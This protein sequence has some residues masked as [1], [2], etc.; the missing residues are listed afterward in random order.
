MASERVLTLRD[1]DF[2]MVISESTAPVLVDFWAE[3]C[4]PCKMIAPVVEEVA[5][6][7]E[8]KI[9]VGKLNVDENQRTPA[10]LKVI[11]IP[12]LIVFKDG[13]EVERSIG[14]K[15]KEELRRLLNKHL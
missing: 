13:Q 4:G 15:T 7:F 5:A 3:W 11:S 2:N 1:A 10:S 14:Y 9:Q 6:E 8:G 12:T